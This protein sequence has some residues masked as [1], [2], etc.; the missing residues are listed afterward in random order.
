MKKLLFILLML[1]P[2]LA[3]AS[4]VYPLEVNGINYYV[5]LEH[6]D[7]T[8]SGCSFAAGELEIPAFVE[9]KGIICRVKSISDEAFRNCTHLTSVILQ[10]GITS[11]G[12]RAFMGCKNLTTIVFPST[13]STI[14]E[15]AFEGCEKLV[16]NELPEK[17]HI[18]GPDVFKGCLSVVPSE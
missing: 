4:E 13:V 8:V 6:A 18:V 17:V 1:L 15:R 12:R 9:Y 14:Y 11:I 10:L 5:D 16:I 3:S 7:A 2:T